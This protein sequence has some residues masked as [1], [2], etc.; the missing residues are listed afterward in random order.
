MAKSQ[1]VKQVALYFGSFNPV[2]IGHMAI[3][4]YIAE[5]TEMDEVWMVISPQN[6]LKTKQSMLANN[7]RLALVKI[8]IGDYSKLKASDIEFALP[9]PSFTI[10]TLI[11]LGLKY[12]NN[13]FTLVLGSD[14]LETF[15]KWKSHEEILDNYGVLVYPRP[16]FIGHALLNLPNVTLIDAPLMEISATFIRESIINKKDIRHFLP[17]GVWEYIK[18][19]HFYESKG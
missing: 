15:H 6:P 4:N 14:N 16:G 10:N 9:I 19:M 1:K 18:E 12:P 7:H 11:K 5:Y 13:K 8:A 17:F 2:H 3:A